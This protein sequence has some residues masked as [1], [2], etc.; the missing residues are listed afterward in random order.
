MV[1]PVLNL[2]DQLIYDNKETSNMFNNYFSKVF[3]KEDTTILPDTVQLNGHEVSLDSIYFSEEELDRLLDKL[4]TNKAH[5]IDK[6]H[7][8]LL[9][10][11][12]KELSKPIYIPFKKSLQ[13]G[14]SAFTM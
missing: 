10:I 1:G 8:A 3:T 6:M 7:Y 9:Q 4:K 12:H 13:E 5:C 2:T 14:K 11:F